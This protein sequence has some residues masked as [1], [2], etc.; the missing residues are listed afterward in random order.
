M[1]PAMIAALQQ[2][3]ASATGFFELD[4]PSGTRRLL[5]G[6]GEASS[7]GNTFKGYD[8]TIGS[9]SSGDTVREDTSGE[10]PNTTLTIAVA[11]G[12]N[13]SDIAGAAIQ[14]SP[15]KIYLAALA[16]DTNDHVIAVPDPELLFD[17]FIDQATSGLDVQKDEVEYT[18]ISAFDY[19][20][21]D[22]EGQRL[23]GQFHQTVWT[24]EHGLDNVTGVTRKIYWGA[25]GPNGASSSVSV[26]TS[27]MSGGGGGF[28]G[29]S[30]FGGRMM[31]V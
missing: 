14:L 9:I 10:A 13:K 2:K 23:N 16:L 21:E 22:T 19:F 3:R 15:V 25:Y 4:L 11:S 28:G 26:G 1:T 6:S 27:F 29:G 7:G 17:G 12:A 18:I 5:L 30:S 31:I 8:S 20:F 24:G